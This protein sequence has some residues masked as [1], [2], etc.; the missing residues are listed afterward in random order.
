[1]IAMQGAGYLSLWANHDEFASLVAGVFG[2]LVGALLMLGF[3]TPIAAGLV[4]IG[5]A[6]VRI[7]SVAFPVANLFDREPAVLLVTVISAALVLTGPGAFSLDC[8]LFGRREVIIPL[9]PVK[10]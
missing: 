2:F 9:S 8:R 5:A 6:Y 7:S 3:L 10:D 4:A 1:M